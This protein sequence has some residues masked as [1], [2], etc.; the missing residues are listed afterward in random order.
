M[1]YETERK[2]LEKKRDAVQKKIAAR[3]DVLKGELAYLD[4]ALAA[5]P[6]TGDADAVD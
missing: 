3:T 4:A 6:T 5:L 1:N 2:R